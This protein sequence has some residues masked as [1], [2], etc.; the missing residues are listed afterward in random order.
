[1]EPAFEHAKY[2]SIVFIDSMVALEGKP[3]ET[4]P[5]HELDPTGPILILVVPQVNSE[6]DKRKR[7]GRLGK[8]ARAFNRLIAPAAETAAPH[9]IAGGPPAIEIAI[10]RPARI[11]WDQYDDLDPGEGDDRVIA[12]I[13]HATDVPAE[14]RR[15]LTHDTNPIAI[16]SRHGLK[17]WRMPDHWLLEPE[18]SPKDKEIAK[19][20]ARVRELEEAQPSI[21]V[22]LQ[23]GPDQPQTVFRVEPVPSD[24]RRAIT[25]QV[26]RRNPSQD[27]DSPYS[28]RRD[29]SY[30]DRYRDYRIKVVPRYTASVHRFLEVLYAQIPFTFSLKNVGSLQAES[31]VL[32]LKTKGGCLHNRFTYHPIFGPAAPK[33]RSSLYPI[34]FAEN[35]RSPPVIGKHEMQFAVGPN[36]SPVIEIHCADFRHGRT[37]EFEGIATIDPHH[38]GPFVIEVEVTASNMRGIRTEAFEFAIAVENTRIG[39]L[40]DLLGTSYKIAFP[41]MER[42][43]AEVRAKNWSWI[44]AVDVDG[45]EAEPDED[46]D[47][48]DTDYED[49]DER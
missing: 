44:E 20:T 15:L 12:Q 5:W 10:A 30:G 16:G 42:F 40:V 9:Q 13:L 38:E 7:D 46:D 47:E 37:W 35:A 24:A 33:P 18:L 41:M 29:Y 17:S 22:S 21:E 45:Q 25:T 28:L 43:K 14:H 27:D 2:S 32:R 31:L 49:A 36:R 26:I 6:I 19:L 39:D 4:L 11:N 23:F 34:R 8:R 3:L 48:E 1:M